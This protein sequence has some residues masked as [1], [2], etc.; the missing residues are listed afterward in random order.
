MWLN[1][2]QP[3]GSTAT[4]HTYPLPLTVTTL[5][6]GTARYTLPQDQGDRSLRTLSHRSTAFSN[7]ARWSGYVFGADSR[8]VRHTTRICPDCRWDSLIPLDSR[9]GLQLHA[10]NQQAATKSDA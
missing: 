3:M 10:Q 6:D 2:V 4:W 8:R 5:P 9:M 1:P 7:A